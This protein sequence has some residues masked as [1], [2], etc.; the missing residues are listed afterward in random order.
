MR[1]SA[2]TRTT[3]S[4]R[5]STGTCTAYPMRSSEGTRTTYSMRS[6]AGTRYA[7]T[8]AQILMCLFETEN[9][10]SATHFFTNLGNLDFDESI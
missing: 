6:S 10:A 7:S 4:M 3:Y 2:G 5:S 8:W 9:P 1:S